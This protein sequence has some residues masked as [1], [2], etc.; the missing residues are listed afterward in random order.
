[1][2]SG[3]VL[4]AAIAGSAKAHPP[5]WFYVPEATRVGSEDATVA[6]IRR[7]SHPAFRVSNSWYS[8]RDPWNRDHTRVLIYETQST[9]DP[10]SGEKGRGMVWGFVKDL[11]S[12]RTLDEYK[13]VA[14]PIVPNYVYSELRNASIYWSPFEGEEHVLYA[15]RSTTKAIVRINV[16]AGTETEVLAYDP[17]DG[18]DVSR[19][20]GLGWTADRHFIVNFDGESRDSGGLEV[21]VRQKTCRRYAEWPGVT[22]LAPALTEVAKPEH[23]AEW[24]R[25]PFVSHGHSSRSPG[26][27]KV[28]LAYGHSRSNGVID[29]A[30]SA[31]IEDLEV[32]QKR[33][34]YPYFTSY[35]SWHSSEKWFLCSSGQGAYDK[36]QPWYAGRPLVL[37]YF[38]WQVYF[39]GTR[40]TYR[41]LLRIK[42]ASRW[43]PGGEAGRANAV[44]NFH[45]HL[46]PI[47]RKD[48][49][50]IYYTATQG[51]FSYADHQ[52]AGVTP[53]SFEGAFLADLL[54]AARFGLLPC[55]LR[56]GDHLTPDLRPRQS[57]FAPATCTARDRRSASLYYAS[58]HDQ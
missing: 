41:E 49:R 23:L 9:T 1:M 19:A 38:I 42:T 16:D 17:N 52:K 48:G 29:L 24:Q 35:V 56:P 13:R 57:A 5:G 18:T 4:V 50:Q 6:G 11:R 58:A 2:V 46:I 33:T 40:F 47:L 53:W 36:S 54:P 10:A 34:P 37:D 7:I 27:S 43:A 22:D 14:R 28:A 45:A 25:F 26:R 20:R 51:T 12:W 39:D 21:D 44:S 8:L 15:V 32:E 3:V 31:F 30:A 55:G